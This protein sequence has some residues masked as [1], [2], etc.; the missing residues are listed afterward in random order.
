MGKHATSVS[1]RPINVPPVPTPEYQ[2]TPKG[3]IWKKPSGK[4]VPLCNITCRIVGDIVYDD[5]VEK[6]REI[7]MEV[8][9]DGEI[10]SFNLP[11]NRFATMGWPIE[12]VGPGAIINPGYAR[13]LMVA[14]QAL[15]GNI[16]THTV[17]E[18]TGWTKF[19]GVWK[20]L[21][22]GGGIGPAGSVPDVSVAMSDSVSG[23]ELPT[24][25]VGK[26]L[27]KAIRASLKLAEVAGP[28]VSIPILAAVYRAPLGKIDSSIHL[29]GSTGVGKSAFAALAQQHYGSGLNSNNFPAS[30]SSTD[31]A[32][33]GKAFILK[34]SLCVVDDF[35]PTGNDDLHRKADRVIRAQGNGLGRGRMRPDGTLIPDKPPRG[36]ILSTGEE[37]PQGF[38]VTARMLIVGM[39]ASSINW[40]TLSLCQAEADEGQYSL[41]MSGYLRS[42]AGRYEDIRNELPKQISKYRNQLRGPH[43][44]T[45][46]NIA[47]LMVG[48]DYLL[49]FAVETGVFSESE[50]DLKRK[51]WHGVLLRVAERQT[52][53]HEDVEPTGQFTELLSA[54]FDSG[55]AHVC[56]ISGSEPTNPK[57]W[58]WRSG[59]NGWHPRGTQIGWV[60][61]DDLFLIPAAAY[62]T[63]NEMARNGAG[64]SISEQTLRKRLHQKNLLLSTEKNGRKTLTIRKTLV[65]ARRPVL[66]LSSKTFVSAD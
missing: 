48:T 19:N 58:G 45:G 57:L 65:G 44:R 54:A 1:T 49:D 46:T 2:E 35:A 4:E 26:S 39:D 3:I 47:N 53:F 10:F 32:I 30:W 43:R 33:E 25:P 66:H 6:R 36:F 42:I 55:R 17:F 14:I 28:E 11:G 34:D 64:I 62:Q 56:S 20:Y 5:G 21:H 8:H 22:V 29:V 51:D 31:N 38:S 41:A 63:A 9:F 60:D 16:P 61:G 50:A 24:V 52:Q 15:S 7:E 13:R 12:Y 59:S 27:Q 40:D 23:F 18:H 37:T